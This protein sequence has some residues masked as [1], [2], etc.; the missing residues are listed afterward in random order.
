MK[1]ALTTLYTCG[2]FMKHSFFDQLN[3]LINDVCKILLYYLP[4]TQ[5]S[6]YK[7]AYGGNAFDS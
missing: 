2:I 1:H 7:S 5:I 4:V 6:P 3:Q